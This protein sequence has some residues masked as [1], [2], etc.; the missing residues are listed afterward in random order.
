MS[1]TGVISE[2]LK[3]TS[4]LMSTVFP[5]QKLRQVSKTQFESASGNRRETKNGIIAELWN[6]FGLLGDYRAAILESLA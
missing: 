1:K 4:T 5:I 2:G 3:W 6:I